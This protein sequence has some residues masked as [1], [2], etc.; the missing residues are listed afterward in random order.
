MKEEQ[1]KVFEQLIKSK[2]FKGKEQLK[3]LLWL[4]TK[5]PKHKIGECFKVTDIS[6]QIYGYTAIDIKAKVIRVYT[7]KDE[8]Q[9]YYELEAIC[10]SDGK[11]TTSKFFKPECVLTEVKRCKDNTNIFDEAKSKHADMS[12]VRL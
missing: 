11:T 4:N 9:Y 6:R 3:H 12:Y 7:Y 8:E 1:I 10:E 2:D 5:Q